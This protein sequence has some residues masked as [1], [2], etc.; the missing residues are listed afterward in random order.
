M[1]FFPKKLTTE[2]VLR[3]LKAE[4]NPMAALTIFNSATQHP[5]YEHNYA[6]FHMMIEKLGNARKI[7]EIDS[8]LV[9]IQVE[10]CPCPEGL[11]LSVFKAYAKARLAEPA[12]EVFR[13]MER[14]F[15]CKPG[16]RSYNTLLNALV[17]GG[18]LHLVESFYAY[19]D[20]VGINPNLQT[21]NVLIKAF[22]KLKRFNEAKKLLLVEMENRGCDPD[23]V[24]YGTL[25]SGLCKEDR[26]K[27][28]VALWETMVVNRCQPDVVCYNILI[29]GLSKS[30]ECEEAVGVWKRML[31]AGCVPNVAGEGQGCGESLVCNACNWLQT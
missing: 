13:N 24:S 17:Q 5:D 15:G 3:L 16:I 10:Q 21:F 27:E 18:C 29:D 25:M 23:A 31:E 20:T 8:I 14:S 9:Q 26:V 2:H 4:K 6:V 7:Q 22:C 11:F 28:A 30:G 12:V 19:L 1:A